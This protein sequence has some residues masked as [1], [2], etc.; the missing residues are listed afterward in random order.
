MHDSCILGLDFL[1]F[2]GCTLNL[3]CKVLILPGGECIQLTSP[4]QQVSQIV[5]TNSL[6]ACA[7]MSSPLTHAAQPDL[8]NSSP[9]CFVLPLHQQRGDLNDRRDSIG[10]IWEKN[11]ACLGAHQQIS[12]WQ[13]LWEFNDILPSVMMRWALHTWYNT[14]LTLVRHVLSK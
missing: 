14:I 1:R 9:D 4:A 11:C 5:P 6:T 7:T 10:V 12:L 13:L 8:P 2:V 3:N